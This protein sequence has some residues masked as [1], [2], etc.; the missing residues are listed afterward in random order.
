MLLFKCSSAHH[1]Q[2]RQQQQG[3]FVVS[4]HL[5]AT[6]GMLRRDVSY[7][8]HCFLC[9]VLFAFLEN[10][11]FVF[12]LDFLDLT[13]PLLLGTS[14][15]RFFCCFQIVAIA[16]MGI[17]GFYGYAGTVSDSAREATIHSASTAATHVY[18]A[19]DKTDAVL[20]IGMSVG[21]GRFFVR[22]KTAVVCV[23]SS[24][25]GGEKYNSSSSTSIGIFSLD[26]FT[27][28]A[29]I[30]AKKVRLFFCCCTQ[31]AIKKI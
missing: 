24:P 28:H 15:R 25:V 16:I 27:S 1:R 21:C 14:F 4:V 23:V 30:Q 7:I 20:S 18:I 8:I 3:V 17:I 19:V 6:A 22:F 5:G 26:F 2:Q 12:G 13:S 10:I 11:P 31:S 9:P 29:Q